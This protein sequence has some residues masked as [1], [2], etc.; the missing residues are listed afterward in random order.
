MRNWLNSLSSP[1]YTSPRTRYYRNQTISLAVI[2]LE[3]AYQIHYG[4]LTTVIEY[5]YIA[6]AQVGP[7][8]DGSFPWINKTRPEWAVNPKAWVSTTNSPGEPNNPSI[9]A[10]TISPAADDRT[11]RYLATYRPAAISIIDTQSQY[12]GFFNK[13]MP[14]F[15][16][17]Y[18]YGMLA[19][20][21]PPKPAPDGIISLELLQYT[22]LWA[23]AGLSESTA[24]STGWRYSTGRAFQ[25]GTGP[26]GLGFMIC[27]IPID[28]LMIRLLYLSQ[29][30]W[31]LTYPLRWCM[32]PP[33][34]LN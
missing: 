27:T 1:H 3:K 6:L 2:D 4:P 5:K 12:R 13:K 25:I 23:C 19:Y 15:I 10:I 22:S 34:R 20:A 17:L 24:D 28:W 29:I 8:I 33:G 26:G 11:A 18:T 32:Y 31:R 9:T 16:A 30:L 7:T 21:G 14:V